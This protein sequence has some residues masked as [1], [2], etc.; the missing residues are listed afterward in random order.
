RENPAA[1]PNSA[2]FL[3]AF[4]N[5]YAPNPGQTAVPTEGDWISIAAVVQSPTS[6]GSVEIKTASAFDHPAIDPAYFS[7]SFDMKTMVAAFK[8]TAK[9]FSAPVWEG[10]IAEA[11]PETAALTTDDAIEAYVRKYT[12]TLKHP[13]ATARISK[14]EEARGIVG[15]NLMVKKIKGVRVVDASV[16]PFAVAGFPQAQVYILA[17]RAAA[18]T[19]ERWAK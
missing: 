16:L 19:K 3:Y 15:P 18:L 1:G 17:D 4:L 13:V 7:A 9:F 2:H 14:A 6:E 12:N 11:A 10:Y 5:T 8:T